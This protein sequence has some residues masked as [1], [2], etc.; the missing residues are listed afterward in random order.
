MRRVGRLQVR[1]PYPLITDSTCSRRGRPDRLTRSDE[2]SP[3]R[4]KRDDDADD[5][6]LSVGQVLRSSD[7]AIR[8]S[9]WTLVAIMLFQQLSCARFL[10]RERP[11][12]T[13]A[14]TSRNLLLAAASMQSVFSHTILAD[15][16][17]Q[18]TDQLLHAQVMY[19]STSCVLFGSFSRLAPSELITCDVPR[20]ILTAVNPTSAQ[21]VSLFMTLGERE[22]GV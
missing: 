5:T 20:R 17:Q 8:K 2:A 16:P 12:Q 1:A 15:L 7:P 4:H 11:F 9:L 3:T 18:S 21:T 6:S 14:D 19:Y 13:A 10:S 22:I